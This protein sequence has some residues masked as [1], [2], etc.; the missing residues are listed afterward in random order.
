MVALRPSAGA[1][2]YRAIE[3]PMG[4]DEEAA[5]LPPEVKQEYAEVILQAILAE[6]LGAFQSEKLNSD[7][8]V[9]LMWNWHN[10]DDA[11]RD[12]IADEQLA[13]WERITEIVAMAINRRP[14]TGEQPTT[15]VTAT[16]GFERSKAVRGDLA[17][18]H[19]FP[20]GNAE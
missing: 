20:L 9:R 2:F 13:S 6:S 3:L 16:L 7:T 15:V 5:A 11:G 10:V 18:V 14:E 19:M 12:E 8:R 1:G 17:A 4:S